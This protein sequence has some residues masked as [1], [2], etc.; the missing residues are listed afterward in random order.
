MADKLGIIN[1]ARALVGAGLQTSLTQNTPSAKLCIALY[2]I[3]RLEVFDLPIDFQFATARKQLA[4]RTET[5]DFG[6]D[7]MYNLPTGCRR[8]Q[9]QVD[10]SGDDVEYEWRREV[11]VTDANKQYDVMLTDQDS[12]VYIKYTVDRPNEGVYPAWFA[13]LIYLNLAHMLAEPLKKD[14]AKAADLFKTF[15]L[16]QIA[17]EAANAIETGKVSSSNVNLIRGNTD[18]VDAAEGVESS[19]DSTVLK[20]VES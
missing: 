13:R 20:V 18:V 2:P 9:K 16:A 8:I 17:A 10:A 5:P 3:A 7:Y 6:Y 4:Q 12:P 14:K 15:E 19:T 1:A 11:Y